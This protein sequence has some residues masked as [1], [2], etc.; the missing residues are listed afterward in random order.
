MISK[1]IA[2]RDQQT[3][4]NGITLLLNMIQEQ[5][6]HFDNLTTEQDKKEYAYHVHSIIDSLLAKISHKNLRLK[7]DALSCLSKISHFP[8]MDYAVQIDRVLATD[9]N[10]S[11]NSSEKHRTYLVNKMRHLQ[12]LIHKHKINESKY[13]QGKIA[14]YNIGFLDNNS[15]EV[16]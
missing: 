8:L 2:D 6:K 11:S 16:R 9:D 4:L 1:G 14:R 5:W 15:P 3:N 13:D 7:S 10:R 12:E